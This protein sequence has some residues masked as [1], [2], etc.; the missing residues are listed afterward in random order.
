[1]RP[2]AALWY[3]TKTPEFHREFAAVN[4]AI[5]LWN[6][7]PKPPCTPAHDCE[8]L[9]LDGVLLDRKIAALHAHGS[10]TR[11]LI[12]MMGADLFRAWVRTEWFRAV[13]PAP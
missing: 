10:Q 5:G 2:E 3:A 4:D 6:E 12:R 11:P 8:S 13:E 1:M 9:T 7:Q